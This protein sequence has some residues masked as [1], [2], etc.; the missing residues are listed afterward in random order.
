M[1]WTHKRRYAYTYMEVHMEKEDLTTLAHA[2]TISYHFLLVAHTAKVRTR[3]EIPH[4]LY[5][6]FR[7]EKSDLVKSWLIGSH[8]ICT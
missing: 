2:S 6:A 5:K 1:R 3:L 4:L 7:I 8:I